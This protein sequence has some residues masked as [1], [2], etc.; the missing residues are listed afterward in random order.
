MKAEISK[1]KALSQQHY[2]LSI[3]QLHARIY[4]FIY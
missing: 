2:A 1:E 4:T 3:K